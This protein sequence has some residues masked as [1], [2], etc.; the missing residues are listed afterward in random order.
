MRTNRIKRVRYGW[1]VVVFFWNAVVADP[2]AKPAPAIRFPS[3]E[4]DFGTVNGDTEVD[5]IFQFANEGNG[6]L[7]VTGVSPACGCMKTIGWDRRV[8]SGETGII[9][10]RFNSAH[11][12]GAFSKSISITCNDPNQPSVTLEIK[13]RIWRAIEIKP[14]SAV[15]NLCAEVPATSTA[16]RLI[17]HADEPLTLSEPSVRGAAVSVQLRTSQPGKEYELVVA[18]PSPMPAGSQQGV[19]TL[20]SSNTNEPVVQIR[21]YVNVLPVL[22]AIPAQIKLPTLPLANAFTNKFWVRNNGTN[23]LML[24][25]PVVNADGV[26]VAIK[27]D[28]ASSTPL[29]VVTVFPA[30]FDAPPG[31]DLELHLK[32][33]DPVVPSLTV[34]ILRTP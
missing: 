20:K 2:A 23:D 31:I 1:V 12:I 30:G 3:T 29:S 27:P 17:S 22:M 15:L 13:G 8:E 10:V 32:S 4:Y 21:T 33:N 5:C 6:V 26:S 7:E 24:S 19:I 16:V 11:Y 14:E 34:P 9:A 25:E 18:S 28:P